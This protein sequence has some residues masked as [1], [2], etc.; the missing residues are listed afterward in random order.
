[1]TLLVPNYAQRFSFASRTARVVQDNS[2]TKVKLIETIYL[3]PKTKAKV[4]YKIQ[5]TRG[6]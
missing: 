4:I 5:A 3:K 1:M 2:K 6:A